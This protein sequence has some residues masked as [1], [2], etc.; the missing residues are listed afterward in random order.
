MRYWKVVGQ[1]AWVRLR[2]YSHFFPLYIYIYIFFL[3]R[4]L[5]YCPGWSA[6]T[7]ISA[8][9]NLCLPGSSNSP[10]SASWVAGVTGMRQHA[11]LIFIFLVETAFHRVDRAGLKFLTSWSARLSL[12]KYWDYR[13][14]PLCLA[15]KH[16]SK[17]TEG[18]K[19]WFGKQSEMIVCLFYMKTKQILL[20]LLFLG[21]KNKGPRM[22]LNYY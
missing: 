18:R 15:Q 22:D 5:L 1:G 8:H 12:S 20:A 17:E 4:I 9:C 13:R 3:V 2:K 16:F 10:A 14:E 11:W 19:G 7:A 21:K 6:V